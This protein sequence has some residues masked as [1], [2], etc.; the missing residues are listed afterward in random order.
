MEIR[1]QNILLRDFVLS[2]IDDEI[3][4]MNVDTQWMKADTPWEDIQPADEE[5]LR[6]Y[7][8][9]CI[10][11]IPEDALR[12]RLEIENDGKHIGF[13]CHYPLDENYGPISFEEMS[14]DTV[15]NWGLGVEICERA[16]WGRGLGTQALVAYIRYL[17]SWGLR[18]FCLETWS[19]NIRML[20]S[21]EKIGFVVCRRQAGL[22]EVD[23]VKYDGLT[24]ALDEEKFRE[25]ERGF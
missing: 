11:N 6:E 4:W 22:R 21:A 10:N 25:F 9:D 1:Y 14:P 3:R 13:I 7:I 12:W 8:T 17:K 15:V 16:Y 2:D 18:A 24:L 20:K 19:G 23:G 5:A